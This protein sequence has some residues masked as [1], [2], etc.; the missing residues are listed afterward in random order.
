MIHKK[1][2]LLLFILISV[3]FGANG[4]AAS[5]K[6]EMRG[7]WIATVVNIDWPSKKGLSVEQQKQEFITML[8]RDKRI[9]I[10]AV[11]VQVRPSG[12]AFYPSQYDPWSEYLTGRQGQPPVPFYDPLKFMIGEAHKRGMELHAWINPYRMVFNTSTSSVAANNITRLHPEWFVTYDHKK[13]FNPGIPQATQYLVGVVSDIINRYDVD[14]IHFDD[15][16]YPYPTAGHFNDDAAYRQYGK[17]M[18]LDD[19]RRSNCDSAIK[20]VHDAIIRYKPMIKFGVS[21]FGIYKNKYQDADG[22]DTRGT[23]DYHDLYADVLLWLKKG[24]I[25]YVAPQLYWPI[26]KQGQD[27]RILLDWWAKHTYG[28]GLYIGHSIA[29]GVREN[30]DEYVSAFSNPN[31]Y[32][33]EIKLLRQYP[34]VNGSLFWSNKSLF[35]DPSGITDSLI[36]NYYKYPALV[37]PMKW[38]DNNAPNAPEIWISQ[39]NS[40]L[41]QGLLSDISNTEIVN[42]Y[43]LYLSRDEAMLGR[44]PIKITGGNNGLQAFYFSGFQD[45]IP[46]GADRFYIAVTSVDKENNE[47][48]LS[49]IIRFQKQRNGLW[50]GFMGH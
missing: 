10:N 43:V 29:Y 22:S 41:V 13:I 1:Y 35:A 26:G 27:Y 33:N 18:A 48:G 31:E 46:P 4:Q 50:R 20:A 7:V 21:P 14:G 47:S 23:T 15:Y 39:D 45:F 44:Q 30:R 6:Y 8:D 11:F 19:W 17:G 12:D 24:W 32:P 34:Q 49:N 40:L 36:N 3:W 42:K 38:I 28:K 5:P 2:S 9:G 25:D 37:P 16:F